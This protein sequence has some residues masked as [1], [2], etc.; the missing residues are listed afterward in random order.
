[1]HSSIFQSLCFQDVLENSPE[2]GPLVINTSIPSPTPPSSALDNTPPLTEDTT[3]PGTAQVEDSHPQRP[4]SPG[5]DI[6]PSSADVAPLSL[7][8]PS[9]PTSPDHP[10][11][12]SSLN[13]SCSLL[14][15]SANKQRRGK[16]VGV[17]DVVSAEFLVGFLFSWKNIKKAF[18]SFLFVFF[19]RFVGCVCV[20]VG[21][22]GC[23]YFVFWHVCCT[24]ILSLLTLNHELLL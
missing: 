13:S 6:P 10:S 5:L 14:E 21:G 12:P 19:G 8:L 18:F 7:T 2:F 15:S 4:S 3:S 17:V 1:M 11:T 24:N 20:C 22:G 9:T 23:L 16:K